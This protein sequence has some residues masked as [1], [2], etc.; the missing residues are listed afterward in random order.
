MIFQEVNNRLEFMCEILHVY[1]HHYMHTDYF[2]ITDDLD[3]LDTSE[4]GEICEIP[5]AYKNINGVIYNL[6][7]EVCIMLSKFK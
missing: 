5:I 3:V 6:T 4:I 1:V 2:V 7:P